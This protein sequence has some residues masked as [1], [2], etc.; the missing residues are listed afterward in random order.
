[1]S[2]PCAGVTHLLYPEDEHGNP[3]LEQPAP[4]F[5]FTC[6]RS[7]PCLRE[8]WLDEHGLWGGLN[9][10]E[11]MTARIRKLTPEEAWQAKHSTPLP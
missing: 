1:M 3:L 4:E 8:G 2:A 11:R 5:C 10:T 9:E 6:P 7:L